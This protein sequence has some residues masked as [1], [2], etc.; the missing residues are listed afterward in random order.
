MKD[1]KLRFSKDLFFTFKSKYLCCVLQDK[2]I[3]NMRLQ[4][5]KILCGQSLQKP[6]HLIG[7]LHE[8]FFI[9]QF[10]QGKT[11]KVSGTSLIL[12]VIVSIGRAIVLYVI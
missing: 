8:N 4:K 12:N 3:K 5:G 6:C 10:S 7:W 11:D 1:I 2:L 9:N